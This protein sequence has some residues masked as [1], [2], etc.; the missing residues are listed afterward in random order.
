MFKKLVA[1]VMCIVLTLLLCGCDLLTSDTA[2]LLSPPSLSGDLKYIS[3]AVKESAGSGYTLK[4]PSRGSYRSAVV[5]K[6]VNNDGVLEAFAFYSMTDGD[7]VTMHINVIHKDGEDWVSAG[8]QHVVAGGVDKVEFS[9]LDGDGVLDIIVGWEIYGASEK[10]LAIYSF[11]ENIVTQRM[12]QKY[13][14][15]VVCN[16]DMDSKNEVLVI[17]FNSAELKNTASLY[18]INNDGVTQLGRCSLD[19]KVQSVGEPVLSQLSSGKNAVYIDCV[20]G[21]GAITEVIFF[22]NGQLLNNLYDSELQENSKTLRS[23]SFTTYDINNDG[24]LE[25]PVQEN[26]PSVA[27][28]EVTE[29][30]YLTKWCS[31]NGEALTNQ[32][33]TMINVLD[34]YYYV[35]Q[36]KWVGNI[37]ILKD[38]DN[39]IREVYSYNSEDLTVGESLLY[40]RAF[41]KKEWQSGKYANL[42]LTEISQD[43]ESVFCCRISE[44]AKREGLSVETVKA[45]FVIYEKE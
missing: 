12:L 11:T 27:G 17:D 31:F 34:G 19:G 30:L 41:S 8:E 43:D 7:V 16:L 24:I 37:A 15:Y 9:D 28:A 26:V 35:L 25:I 20:K 42:G 3:Q 13:T 21:L 33:T 29:K 44:K 18:T 39:R 5:Q 14:D 23:A 1:T 36:Q 6:D 40:L 38:T 45:N 32:L 22:E 10:Q 2:E 4:Y